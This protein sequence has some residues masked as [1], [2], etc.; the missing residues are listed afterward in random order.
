MLTTFQLTDG[1]ERL[2]GEE[3]MLEKKETSGAPRNP[4]LPPE[5]ATAAPGGPSHSQEQSTSP[6][7]TPVTGRSCLRLLIEIIKKRKN[8]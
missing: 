3:V 2:D 7:G 5:I 4:S 6:S 1:A 8:P